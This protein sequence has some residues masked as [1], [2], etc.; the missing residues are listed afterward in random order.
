MNNAK[1]SWRDVTIN[2]YF[3]LLDI[4][5]DETLEPYDKEVKVI[6]FVNGMDENEVW[7][8]SI[9][10]FKA[11][12]AKKSWMN[13]FDLNEK[14]VFRKIKIGDIKCDVNVNLQNF[15]VAQYIDFQTFWPKRRE[16]E[17]YMGNILA[18]FIIPTGCKYNEGYDIQKLSASITESLDI[19]TANEILLF[20]LASYLNSTR[21]TLIYLRLMMMRTMRRMKKPE[22]KEKMQALMQ[23]I[24]AAQAS[25]LDGFRSLTK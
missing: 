16:M 8:L 6:A 5:N 15:T 9:T 21:A 7:N 24:Q 3:E 25:I 14:P 4:V 10:D 12:Q 11:L 13:S 23:E 2:E 18:C 20:F 17:K 1:K 19:M 22:Q